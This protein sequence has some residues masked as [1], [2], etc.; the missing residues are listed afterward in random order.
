MNGLALLAG[1][2][3]AL[4]VGGLAVAVHVWLGT[5][6]PPAPATDA[7][8]AAPRIPDAPKIPDAPAPT[9]PPTASTGGLQLLP[10]GN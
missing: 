1:V 3:G 4:I 10:A 2:C 9:V 8:P 7:A 6:A 5:D